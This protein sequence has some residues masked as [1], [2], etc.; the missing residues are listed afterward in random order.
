MKINYDIPKEYNTALVT[1]P[2]QTNGFDSL[3][4][5]E[6]SSPDHS[7]LVLKLLPSGSLHFYI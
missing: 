1:T 6:I 4:L 3:E 5:V 2:S 7:V